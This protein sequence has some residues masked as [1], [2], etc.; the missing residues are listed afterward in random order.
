MRI[1]IIAAILL[2][3]T[4][5]VQ[6]SEFR[7]SDRKWVKTA[8]HYGALYGKCFYGTPDMQEDSHG[9]P[10]APVCKA[11]REA[12]KKLEANGYC[13]VGHAVVGRSGKKYFYP[14]ID[15]AGTNSHMARHCYEI[16][17]PTK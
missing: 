3:L 9:I 14:G 12:G 11:M 10:Q 8:N 5:P 2:V 4:V 15:S 1:P 17:W 16:N 6:A 7:H 13:L